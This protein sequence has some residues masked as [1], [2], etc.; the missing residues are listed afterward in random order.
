M[1]AGIFRLSK[2]SHQGPI[3]NSAYS[4]GAQ[5]WKSRQNSSETFFGRTDRKTIRTVSRIL[6]V[7]FG[8]KTESYGPDFQ[9]FPPRSYRGPKSRQNSNELFFNRTD[10][11]R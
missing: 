3:F 5:V 2:L 11:K 9:L 1:R 8:C 7:C 4:G 10:R 6:W